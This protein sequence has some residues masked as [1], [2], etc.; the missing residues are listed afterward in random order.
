MNESTNTTRPERHAALRIAGHATMR[1][2]EALMLAWVVWF[3]V[4]VTLL[5]GSEDAGATASSWMHFV[6]NGAWE[7]WEHLVFVHDSAVRA[8]AWWL[9]LAC[10]ALTCF[11]RYR[12]PLARFLEG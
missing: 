3:L 9:V 1:F 10:L 5:A 12:K 11:L 8:G 7:F 2:L 4:D 6:K